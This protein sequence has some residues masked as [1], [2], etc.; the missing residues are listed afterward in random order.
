MKNFTSQEILDIAKNSARQPLLLMLDKIEDP[1]NFGAILRTA[2][3]AGV[4]GVI[5]PN[6]KAVQVTDTVR[7]TST[8]ASE[9]VPVA[10][11]P[12][13]VRVME[14]YKKQ[15]I[16]T[17]GIEASGNSSIYEIDAEMPLLVIAG[18]EGDGLSRLV[19]EHCDFLANIPML[20]QITSLNVSV[21]VGITLYEFIRQRQAKQ[22]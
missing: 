15:G 13:L 3:A 9:L 6:K 1:G 8:G 4:Q 10:V 12:N 19:R 16:W 22:L 14:E 17:V 2:E 11:V 18:S 20:G 5:I 21:A 7:K